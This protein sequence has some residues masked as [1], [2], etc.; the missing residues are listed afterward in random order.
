VIT[1][2]RGWHDDNDRTSLVFFFKDGRA[3]GLDLYR[4]W[5]KGNA[6]LKPREEREVGERS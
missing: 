1:V 2:M 6:P 5:V 4:E 3:V